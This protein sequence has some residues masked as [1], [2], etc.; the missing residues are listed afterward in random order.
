MISTMMSS[1]DASVGYKRNVLAGLA[2]HQILERGLHG[3]TVYLTRASAA[4]ASADPEHPA[5]QAAR[6]A[7]H[8]DKL[9]VFLSRIADADAEMGQKLVRCYS[10]IQ[11]L[12]AAA[13]AG[14]HGTPATTF[15]RA[16]SEARALE[17]VMIQ[18]HHSG[19]THG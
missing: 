6:W 15:S 8:A 2:A 13:L 19:D 9:L 5:P 17:K 1:P 11:G 3:V 16:A 4:A 10:G 12:I 7:A 14:R 18:R